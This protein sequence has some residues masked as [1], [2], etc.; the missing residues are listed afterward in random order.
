MEYEKIIESLGLEPK[1]ADVFLALTELGRST[2][3]GLAR[4]LKMPRTSLYN[5]IE[6]LSGDGFIGEVKV[7]NHKEWEAVSPKAFYRKTKERIEDL[8]DII[9][10]LEKLRGGDKRH[11]ES[12]ILFYKGREGVRKAYDSIL[13]LPKGERVY[14]IEG[15]PSVEA[16][17]RRLRRSYMLEWQVAFKKSGLV[18]ETAISEETLG[19]V[20]KLDKELLEYHLGRP[21][22]VHIIPAGLMKFSG[23]IISYKNT[24]I[25]T[26][27]ER[28]LTIIINN[29]AV[30]EM[31]RNL[32]TIILT[33]GKKIDFNAF[34]AD[35]VRQK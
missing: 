1:E 19:V 27:V 6:K 31:F 17:S 25:I 20:K 22:I 10:E 35:V 12:E 24:L 14:S 11:Q 9:P 13:A 30:A 32:F 33:A 29:D 7:G 34:I 16:K 18:W 4:K 26:S 15:F 23:E 3:S 21:V 2:I 8:Q 5:A 28:D